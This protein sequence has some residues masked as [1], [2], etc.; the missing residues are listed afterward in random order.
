MVGIRLRG[1]AEL[2]DTVTGARIAVRTELPD[3]PYCVCVDVT[4]SRPR[5]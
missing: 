1:V 3:R 5:S 4:S 2:L